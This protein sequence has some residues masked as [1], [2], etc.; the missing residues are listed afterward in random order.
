MVCRRIAAGSPA[1]YRRAAAI[2]GAA[3]ATA[4]G[5]TWIQDS[6]NAADESSCARE[7]GDTA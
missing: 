2:G 3:E 6:G 4:A 7:E 5:G 1:E